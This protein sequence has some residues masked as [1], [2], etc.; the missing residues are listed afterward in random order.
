MA[1]A[2]IKFANVGLADAVVV[3][4]V[5]V[6]C[7]FVVVFDDAVTVFC[8]KCVF[9]ALSNRIKFCWLVDASVTSPMRAP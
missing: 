4:V 6:V 2:A 5:V 8:F 7:V 9:N 3:V 1:A